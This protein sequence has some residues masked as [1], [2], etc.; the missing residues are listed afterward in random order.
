MERTFV[1]IKPDGLQ[2]GLVG[3]IIQRIEAKGLKIVA[4]KMRTIPTDVAEEHYVEHVEKPF[5]KDLVG[6]ITS[7]P[8]VPMVV[9]GKGAIF[10]V[11]KMNGATNP[12]K[13]Q[14]GTIRGDFGLDLGRNV[15]HG[16]DSPESAAREIAL[17]FDESE[18]SIYTRID[19]AWLY[20]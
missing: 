8:S 17:H 3:R 9:E 7:G 12:T 20:E 10:E 13:A 6:F 5:F 2:R 1:M 15:I 14:P 18:L 11:R 16:S 4:M 19:E